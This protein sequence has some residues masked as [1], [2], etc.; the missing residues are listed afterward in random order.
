MHAVHQFLRRGL[1][2]VPEDVRCEVPV[3]L[4]IRVAGGHAGRDDDVVAAFLELMMR[5]VGGL[6]R[7]VEEAV[8]VG[9]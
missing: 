1:V 7:T 6:D 5:V 2:V 9:I 3:V 8:G 4:R